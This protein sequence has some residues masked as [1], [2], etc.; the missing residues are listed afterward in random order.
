[1]SFL[2]DATSRETVTAAPLRELARQ[3]HAGKVLA[4]C[5]RQGG[6]LILCRE[7]ERTVKVNGE[8]LKNADG[9]AKRESVLKPTAALADFAHAMEAGLL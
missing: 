9:S 7:R 2:K 1:M 3:S 8:T 5:E 6:A 4:V